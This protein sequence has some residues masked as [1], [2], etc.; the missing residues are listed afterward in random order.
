MRV[1]GWVGGR[2]GGA[3]GGSV[4]LRSAGVEGGGLGQHACAA[5]IGL[6]GWSVGSRRLRTKTRVQQRRRRRRRW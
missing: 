4:R 3:R 5:V 6:L 2:E 1:I